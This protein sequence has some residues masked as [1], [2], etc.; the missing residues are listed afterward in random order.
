L[1]VTQDAAWRRFV[2]A[3]DELGGV[4]LKTVRSGALLLGGRTRL[5][6]FQTEA[7]GPR[8]HPRLQVDMP[9]AV[10]PDPGGRLFDPALDIEEA[11]EAASIDP[12]EI[13]AYA[14]RSVRGQRLAR[15]FAEVRAQSDLPAAQV[16]AIEDLAYAR[17][18]EF[19][20]EDTG[21]YHSFQHDKPFVHY[22]EKILETLPPEGTEAFVSLPTEQQ[23]SVQRQRDQARNHLDFVMRHK[24]ANHGIDETDIEPTLGGLL[25]DRETR[26]I[27]SERPESRDTLLPQYELLRI[28][29]ALQHERA[30]SWIFRSEAGL[31]LESGEAIDVPEDSVRRIPI[32]SAN[33]TFQRAPKDKRLRAGVRFDWDDSGHIQNGAISWVSWAGHCDIKAI[34][35]SLGIAFGSGE[36]LREWRSDTGDESVWSR[37]LLLEMMAS[38]LELGSVYRPFDGSSDRVRGKHEFGGARNDARPDRLQFTGLGQGKH[39]RWPLSG[40][41]DAF[42]I[43]DIEGLDPSAAFTRFTA[44]VDALEMAE[45]PN[46]IK[47]VEGDYNLIEVGDR[48]LTCTARVDSFDASGS[49][50]HGTETV[51]IDLK[52]G[53]GR[54][55]LGTHIQDHG[56]REIFRLYLDYDA[57]K[58]VAELW[59]WERGD[60]GFAEVPRP[61]DNVEIELAAPLSCTASRETRFDDPA[62]FQELLN[63]ALRGGKNICA[64]TDMQAPV[65]NGVVLSLEAK[66]TG[67]N[68]ENR[69][70]AWR[71]DT[72][73]RFGDA[74]LS[75]LM[76]RRE[77]GHPEAYCPIPPTGTGKAIDF[78]WRDL[79]DVGTKGRIGS[80]W[81]VNRSAV[82]RKIVSLRSDPSVPGGMYVYDD[83]LKN[84]YEQL[85]AAMSAYRWTITHANKRWG[86]TDEETWK[87]AVAE[88]AKLRSELTFSP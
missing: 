13:G 43:T 48:T 57:P 29:P 51:T 3:I 5:T 35:E 52:S 38:V 28:D 87:A 55:F 77:D 15:F 85:Y 24:Y 74:S 59:A 44:D 56:E 79:P 61:D 47:V 54:T 36:I 16:S 34:M 1:K 4:R 7:E 73:A 49:P 68:A 33:L 88:L 27:A 50:S 6:L 31:H 62:I 9:D 18:I 78:L 86:F 45:N 82:D 30:G 25:I 17:K 64:D 41:Q 63:T 83:H 67:F 65:W 81:V 40:R 39:F 71:V 23:A 58:I 60:E 72:R 37:D 76:R 46:F 84:V 80:D 32:S 11:L 26:H 20:D 14:R 19:E 42:R 22:L 21:T 8:P 2:E 10:D 70:E 69:I 66:R 75:W 12:G 53:T